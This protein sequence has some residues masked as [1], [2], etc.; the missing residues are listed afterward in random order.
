MNKSELVK[1]VAAKAAISQKDSAKV[2]EA[3]VDTVKEA[4]KKG[5]KVQLVGFGSFEVRER[6][7]RKVKSPATGE[8]IQVPEKRVAVFRPGKDLK[9]AVLKK[10]KG[11][12]TKAAKPAKKK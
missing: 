7:A 6:K 2:V 10:G 5:D 12:A 3:F 9:E 11:R 4:L 1:S 8:D